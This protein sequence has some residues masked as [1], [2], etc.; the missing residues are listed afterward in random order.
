[1]KSVQVGSFVLAASLAATVA[2]AGPITTY[3][4]Y[5]AAPGGLVT[6]D[7]Q[8]KRDAFAGYLRT[9]AAKHEIDFLPPPD[10]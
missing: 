5:T 6:G 2:S 9:I 3:T 8:T 1:M 7:A 4:G 10:A